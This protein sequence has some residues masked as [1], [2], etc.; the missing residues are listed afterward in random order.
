MFGMCETKRSSK[1]KLSKCLW[2]N[3]YGNLFC[4]AKEVSINILGQ[5]LAGVN[6]LK[7]LEKNFPTDVQINFNKIF[8]KLCL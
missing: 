1:C 4:S 2:K 6:F 7:L 5:I 8:N 3:I